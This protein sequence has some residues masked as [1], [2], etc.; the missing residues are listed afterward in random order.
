MKSIKIAIAAA[1][2]GVFGMLK[3][4]AQ[5]NTG[6][7]IKAGKEDGSV[8]LGS[9]V[10][11]LLKSIGA[12]LNGGWY[13]T[14]KPLGKGGF[15]L[16]SSINTIIIPSADKSFDVTSLNLKTIKYVDEPNNSKVSPTVFGVDK[17]G[18]KME[19]RANI[20]GVDTAY[21]F[22]LPQGSGYG[23]M[24]IPV[25][26]FNVGLIKKTEIGVRYM[27][28]V[29]V[30]NMSA[31]LKGISVMHDLKQWIPGLKSLPVDIFD[32]SV[33][34][35]YTQFNSEVKFEG[36]NS[37]QASTDND[38]Y[39][40]NPSKVY[41]NQRMELKGSAWNANI[42]ASKKIAILTIYAGVGYQSS[43]VETGMKGD[44]PV[45]VF[46]DVVSFLNPNDPS[47]GKYKRVIEVTDPLST[48]ATLSGVRANAGFRL[49][50]TVFSLHADYTYSQYPMVTFGLGVGVQSLLPPKIN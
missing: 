32:L 37:I 25:A 39:N 21:K 50:L 7:I 14:A 49:K 15:N 16:S 6:E 30:R 17:T 12:G 27:P 8:L 4:Q 34:A 24:P 35:A 26:Q 38:T 42:V 10:N 13:Q 46:N 3:T 45:T 41:T 44:Y 47:F 1:S 23:Y 28:P 9:Y 22:N 40:P 43:T 2:I 5:I 18:S 19:I 31:S 11:P 33:M 48:K 20:N 36:G 29:N